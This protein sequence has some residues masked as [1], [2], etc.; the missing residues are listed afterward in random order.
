MADRQISESEFWSR[1]FQSQLWERHRASVRK[2][3]NDDVAKRKDDIF[4]Q[5]LEDPDWGKLSFPFPVRELIGRC[6]AK[7]GITREY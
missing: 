4:D 2:T 7:S 1:Y 3:A 5:Y 6:D